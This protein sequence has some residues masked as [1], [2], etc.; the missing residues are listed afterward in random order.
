MSVS[1]IIESVLS[2]TSDRVLIVSSC[3]LRA[4]SVVWVVCWMKGGGSPVEGLVMWVYFC[5]MR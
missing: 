4:A 5:D 1:A 3:W 2:F